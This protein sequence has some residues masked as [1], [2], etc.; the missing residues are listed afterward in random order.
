MYNGAPDFLREFS[1]S[2]VVLL[3]NLILMWVSGD[4][5]VSAYGVIANLGNVVV[6]GLAG[7]SNAVQPLVSYNIGAGCRDRAAQLLRLGRIAS[8]V[9]ALAYVVFAELCPEVLVS[10]FL[11]HPTPALSGLC[12]VGIR[13]ISPA[14][15]LAGQ[16][17]L[18]NVYFEAVHAPR[19]AFWTAMIR[20]LAAPVICIVIFVLLWDVNGVWIAF[21]V[22]EA[23]GLLAAALMYRGVKRNMDK[24]GAA[25]ALCK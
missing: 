7:V 6:C 24:G 8:L 2:V 10:A 5:A 4:T 20:G 23:V 12:R 14:Y 22:S 15:V 13:I 11:D 17:V 1:G 18:L 16:A 25:P 9:L 19:Q 21:I 3:V